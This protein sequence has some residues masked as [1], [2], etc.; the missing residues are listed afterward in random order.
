MRKIVIINFISTGLLTVATTSMPTTA[1]F[2]AS[3]EATKRFCEPL[4]APQYTPMMHM[5]A[6]SIGEVVSKESDILFDKLL[7]IEHPFSNFVDNGTFLECK[8]FDGALKITKT[9]LFGIYHLLAVL[10]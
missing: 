7:T 3:Y 2:F 4:V 10:H 5:F 6:A 1:L 9:F 8:T